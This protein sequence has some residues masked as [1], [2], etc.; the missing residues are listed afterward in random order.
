MHDEILPKWLPPLLTTLHRYS[1]SRSTADRQVLLHKSSSSVNRQQRSPLSKLNVKTT[2]TMNCVQYSLIYFVK[3][4]IS[5]CYSLYSSRTYGMGWFFGHSAYT[6]YFYNF[7]I[8]FVILCLKHAFVRIINTKART[9]WYTKIF[10][11]NL[12]HW[13]LL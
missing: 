10:Y 5:N 3:Q 12:E 1:R 11:L 7:E 9:L 6:V 4:Q 8:T 13:N 2:L